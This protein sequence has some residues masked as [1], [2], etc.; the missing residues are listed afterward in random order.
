MGH[1]RHPWWA[2]DGAGRDLEQRLHNGSVKHGK[3]SRTADM[4]TF[5][6]ALADAGWTDVRGFSDPTARSLL[7]PTWAARL[8]AMKA[9]RRGGR[10][11]AALKRIGNLMALRTKAIDTCVQEAV[12]GGA[13]QLVILGAGL[14]GRAFRMQGLEAVDVF[15]VDHPD[16]QATKRERAA[17]LT[18]KARSLQF[19]A[20]DFER[21]VLAP[22]LAAA[23][24]RASDPSVWIWEGVVMYLRDEAVHATLAAIATQS[25]PGSTLVIQYNT[26]ERLNVCSRL[27]LRLLGEPQIGLRTPD[28]FAGELVAA[29][30]RVVADSGSADW[31]V[32][33]GTPVARSATG[34]RMVIARR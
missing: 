16:T 13:H 7:P 24:H 9:R 15:E 11:Q 34:R 33:F 17:G 18:L 3:S 30:F 32:R 23:G 4:V 31:G 14:D 27:L 2:G 19:V 1:R 6:R 28:R 25:A 5:G 21:D 12:V 29:G 22:A 8:D 10:Q 26:P 20:V